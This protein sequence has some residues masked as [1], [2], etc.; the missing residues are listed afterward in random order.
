MTALTL[1][2]P[3]LEGRVLLLLLLPVLQQGKLAQHPQHPKH[4]QSWP[5]TA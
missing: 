5:N 3:V 4:T 2:K 1:C